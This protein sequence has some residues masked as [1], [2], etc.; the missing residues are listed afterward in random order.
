[1]L[2]GSQLALKMKAISASTGVPADDLVHETSI[3][4]LLRGADEGFPSIHWSGVDGNHFVLAMD[5]LGPNLQSLKYVCRGSL[6]LRTV[7][8][9]AEQMVGLDSGV[10][11]YSLGLMK[12]HIDHSTS[13][14]AF[15]GNHMRRR[16]APQL[17]HGP[18]TQ[19]QDCASIR[20]RPRR[21][22]HESCHQ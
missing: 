12:L 8:M 5:L 4:K 3:Y 11:D 21:V 6:S 7:C 9:L 15:E 10:S 18:R 13:V 1:M 14:R 19:G 2:T 20:L 17:C 22:L 16:E